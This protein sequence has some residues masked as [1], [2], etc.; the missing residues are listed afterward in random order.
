M[1]SESDP[2]FVN[3]YDFDKTIYVRDSSTDFWLWCLRRRPRL[4]MPTL[5]KTLAA[6]LRWARGRIDTKALKEQLFSFLPRL[7]AEAEAAL[8]WETHGEGIGTWYL[9]QRRDDDLILS[10]SPEFLLRPVAE[11]L[12]FRLIATPMDPAT[13]RINGLNCHDAE[14]VRRFRAEY[15][16]AQAEDFYSDSLSDT[17]MAELAQR[18]F[19]VRKGRLAPWPQRERR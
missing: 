3:T 8:F 7:D 1:L 16:G 14:K 13:G 9:A 19:L 17:P 2:L 15:P 12:G 6:A 5:P 10:A 11:K 18:A 4:L